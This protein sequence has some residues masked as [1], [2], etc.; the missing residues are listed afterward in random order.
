MIKDEDIELF[1]NTVNKVFSDNLAKCYSSFSSIGQPIVSNE[2]IRALV[3]DYKDTF[4]QNYEIM[5][6]IFNI[7]YKSTLTRN[8]H[9]IDHGYYDR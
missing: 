8:R 3:D 7:H 6:S 9:L 5:H 4:T 1:S 2:Q